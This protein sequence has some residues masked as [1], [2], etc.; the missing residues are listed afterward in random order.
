LWTRAE[1]KT[2]AKQVLRTTYWKSLLISLVL[3]IAGGDSGGGGSTG[4]SSAGRNYSNYQNGYIS[5]FVAALIAIAVI[6]VIAAILF[7]ILI[8]FCLEVGGRRFF[9]QAAQTDVNMGYLGYA[10]KSDRYLD[11]IKT[12][13]YKGVLNFLWYLLL[14]IPGIVKFYAYRMVPYIL[15]DNPNIGY[16]RAVELSMRMTDGHKFDMFVLDLSFIGWYLLGGLLFGIGVIFVMPYDY[17]TKAELYLVLRQNAL[18]S[19]YCGYDE[20]LLEAEAL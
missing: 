3:L 1:L 12:M 16:R 20:L 4:G 17:A 6:I 9:I 13:M 10:F 2:R 15:A 7:R 19:G 11:I 18:S 14:I 5:E 8:G